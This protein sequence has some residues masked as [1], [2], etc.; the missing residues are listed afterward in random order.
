MFTTTVYAAT[1]KPVT[2]KTDFDYDAM[3]IVPSLLSP[4]KSDIAFF[5]DEAYVL[6]N[7]MANEI[8]AKISSLAESLDL[9]IAVYVGGNYRTDTETERYTYEAG[10]KLFGDS[11][12]ALFIYI[13]FEGYSPAYDYIRAFNMAQN[14]FTETKRNKILNA[15]YKYLPKSTE[16]IYSE[17]VR[18]G[19]LNGLSEIER[20]GYS[21]ETVTSYSASSYYVDDADYVQ[22]SKSDTFSEI[23]DFIK[24]IPSA[25]IIGFI[26]FIVVSMIFSSIK[27]KVNN[28]KNKTSNYHN[29]YN[30]NG[31]NN[32]YHN[33]YNN[34]YN[35]S[36]Y[37]NYNNNYNDSYYNNSSRN[38]SYRKTRTTRTSS[39]SSS[40]DND[41]Y[42]N[43]SYSNNSYNDSNSN[44]SDS[45]GSGHHR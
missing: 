45:S 21:L 35:D 6:T 14:V 12:D 19:I 24:N 42:D 28:F 30:D 1:D 7:A 17:K 5:K 29:Y 26:A 40:Y 38:R 18:K 43:S 44:S 22:N 16:P 3:D 13:D 25:A 8:Y 20:M 32:S 11:S 4:C 15:M 2:P 37:N 9:K 33:N 27:R 39:R 34:N 10:K 31:Y 36:Y 41:R 23:K